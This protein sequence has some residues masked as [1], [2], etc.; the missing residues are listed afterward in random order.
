L[1]RIRLNRVYYGVVTIY[2]KRII[3]RYQPS[4]MIPTSQINKIRDILMDFYD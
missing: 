4:V 2:C 3:R 1:S